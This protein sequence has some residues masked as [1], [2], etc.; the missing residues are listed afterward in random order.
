MQ[1]RCLTQSQLKKLLHYSPETG[2][3]TWIARPVRKDCA[4]TDKAWNS[5]WAG[6]PAGS[7][8]SYGYVVVSLGRGHTFQASRLA[9][10]YM[11]GRWPNGDAEHADRN[12]SN[13]AWT[14]LREATRSENLANRTYKKTQTGFKGVIKLPNGKYRARVAIAGKMRHIGVFWDA[15]SASD[16]VKAALTDQYG[17]FARV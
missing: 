12:Q 2:V 8:N 1:K 17:S 16:A 13:N 3:F 9:F 4:R 15:E 10:L 14:N 11:K 5:A 7:I 6:K